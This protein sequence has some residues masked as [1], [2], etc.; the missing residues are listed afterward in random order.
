MHRRH[1]F[2][3][4]APWAAV[5]LLCLF[6]SLQASAETH[7]ASWEEFYAYVESQ[8]DELTGSACLYPPSEARFTLSSPPLAFDSTAFAELTNS[9]APRTLAGVPSWTMRVVETQVVTRVWVAHVEGLPVRTNA[10]PA[11]DPE[12][13]SRSAYGT[14]PHWLDG[15]ELASWYRERARERIEVSLTLIPDERFDEY[16]SNLQASATNG[17]PIPTAPVAPAD[18]NRVAFARVAPVPPGTFGFDLYTPDDLPVDIFTKTNLLEGPLWDYAGTVLAAAPFTPA[19][20]PTA[21][22]AFFLHAARGDID[23]DGDGIPDGLEILHFGTN[24]ALRDTC[25]DG[26]S[27]WEEI[28][29][30][31][32]NPLL[33]DSDGD[34][35]DD[36]YEIAAA[37]FRTSGG[38]PFDTSGGTNLL[39]QFSSMDDACL[40]IPLPFQVMIGGVLCTNATLDM[41]GLIYLWPANMQAAAPSSRY[42]NID[43]AE[44]PLSNRGLT[45]VPFW[46][47]LYA[48]PVELG[49]AILVADV[50]RLGKRYFVVEYNNFGFYSEAGNTNNMVSFQ[51]AIPQSGSNELAFVYVTAN[52][53]GKGDSA[54]VGA[55]GVNGLPKLPVSY[56]TSDSLSAGDV[57]SF[58]IGLGT[59]PLRLDTDGDGL[60]DGV[61]LVMGTS[62][63]T[64]DTDDDGLPDGW[65]AAYGLDPLDDSGGDGADGDPDLDDL[66]N[67]EEFQYATSPVLAD[68]DGD[69]VSDP[70]YVRNGFSASAPADCVDVPVSVGDPSGSDSER[71]NITLTA[72]EP[73]GRTYM[74]ASG[75]YGDMKTMSLR[76][77]RG[78]RYRAT[79]QHRGTRSETGPDYDW[80]AQVGGLPASRVLAAS[81]THPE[82]SRWFAVTNLGVIVDNED[83]LLGKCNQLFGDTNNAQDKEAIIYILSV[84]FIEASSVVANNSAQ[85]FEGNMTDFGNPCEPDDPGQ[86]LVVFHKDVRDEDFVVQDYDVTLKANILPASITADQLSESWGKVAGPS[87]G[88]LNLTDTF[89]VKYQ[90]AKEGGLYQFE[91]DLGLSGCTKSGANLLLPLGGPDVTAYLLSE[92]QR[93]EDWLIALKTR[94]QTVSDSDWVKAAIILGHTKRTVAAMLHREGIYE[95]GDSPCKRFCPDTITVEQYVFRQDFMGNFLFGFLSSKIKI[96]LGSAKLAA[97]IVGEGGD[98]PDDYAAIDAG[99]QYGW[100]SSTNLKQTLE[101]QGVEAMQVEVAKRGWPSTDTAVGT[102]YPTWGATLGPDPD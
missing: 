93:Y 5:R 19:A 15:E 33:R 8:Y 61:E 65:E 53:R 50:M 11:Y 97:W 43:L 23:N 42:N 6:A 101:D 69:G 37:V 54:S 68:T 31:G 46:D 9:V 75:G 7:L 25:G 12:S 28:Y 16:L 34:G 51:V 70:D 29:R 21:D 3:R 41:N 87:S 32:L 27:D 85:N 100:T 2:A 10:V 57:I 91:F 45:L 60:T 58:L 48:R 35:I 95:S 79:L 71:W 24:P 4:R 56:N 94:V 84:N 49:T 22:G 83:G 99:Y 73:N 64:A 81:Q 77:K 82:L 18:S 62:P 78:H 26:L 86:A 88:S 47:D 66:S 39:S 80:E 20:V 92:A 67:W 44:A 30:Y 13:W 52:G 63:V 102:E 89:E 74:V 55:Q 14:P 72:L 1:G 96:T 40:T 90:N 76:L 17:P 36:G 38:E 98:E 59:H